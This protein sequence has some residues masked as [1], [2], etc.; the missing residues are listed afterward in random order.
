MLENDVFIFYRATVTLQIYDYNR[1]KLVLMYFVYTTFN[2]N[3]ITALD[4][5]VVGR[6]FER[7]LCD[8]KK[9]LSGLFALTVGAG[10]KC[11][12]GTHNKERSGNV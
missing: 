12:C 11:C 10:C 8:G 2:Y 7:R 4:C 5:A 1:K 3:I 9:C 6:G